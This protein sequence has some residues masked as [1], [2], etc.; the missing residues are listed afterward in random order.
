M[1]KKKYLACTLEFSSLYCWT[2]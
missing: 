1:Y 2:A